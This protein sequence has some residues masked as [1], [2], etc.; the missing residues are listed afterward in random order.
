M[1]P[2]ASAADLTWERSGLSGVKPVKRLRTEAQV[3][4]GPSSTWLPDP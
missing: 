2:G 3:A 4:K 1:P